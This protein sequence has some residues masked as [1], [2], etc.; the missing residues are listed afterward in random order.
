MHRMDEQHGSA[1]QSTR[2]KYH[3]Q[4]HKGSYLKVQQNWTG[5]SSIQVA[6]RVLA[7]GSY[8]KISIGLPNFVLNQLRGS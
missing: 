8:S 2:R 7:N 5:G 1:R 6:S 4:N 3:I